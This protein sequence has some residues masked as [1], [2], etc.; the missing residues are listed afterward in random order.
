MWAGSKLVRLVVPVLC[1][2]LSIF[3]TGQTQS[4]G[5]IAGA[6]RD[7]QGAVIVGAEVVVENPATT[8][9]RT[10][11]S[12]S[13]GNYSASLLPPANYDLKVQ[14]KGFTSAIFHNL[15]VG[16][17]GTTTVNAILQVAQTSFEVNV[18][19]A[20]PLLRSDSSELSTTLDSRS[21]TELPLPTRNLLQLLT[22][23][24]GVTAPLTNNNTIGR[25]SPNVSVNGSRV[26]QNSY[27]INGIDANDISLHEF[28]DVAVP[29]PESISEVDVE[30]SLYDASVAGA[31]GSL[32]AVTKS[33]G[34]LL[35]GSAY[36]YFRNE[37]FNAND[38]N[39]KGE[40]RPVMRRNVY[41]ATLGGPLRKNRAFFF[42]AY[43]GTREANGATDQSLYK[44]VLIA[45]GLTNDRS[46]ATLMSTFGVASIDPIAL[47]LLNLQLPNGQFLIPTPQTATGRVTGTALSTYHEEQFS[48][49]VDYRRSRDLLTGKF[50]F[51][52]APL[53]S[54]LAGSNFGTPA[55]LP[56]FGTQITIDNRVLS[57][58][59]I[60]TFSPTAVN[61]IRFGY[62]FIRH[63][64]LPQE[65]VKDSAIGIQRSTSGQYPGLPLIVLGRDEGGASIGTSDITYRGSTPSLSIGDV[66]SLQR[67]KHNLRVGGEI[68]HPEWHGR[69]AVLSYGE[70]D[71]PTF[72][73]FLIGNT[74]FS[75]FG[76]NFGFAHLG[77]GL[78]DR[79]FIT[80]DYHLFAQDDWKIS[81]KFTLNLG[82]RYEL[83]SPPYDSQGRIGGF[84]PAFYRPSMQVDRNGFPLGPP[85][86]GITE[87]GNALP[88]YSLPGVTRV[89]KRV[90]KSIDP[91]NFGP[92]IGLAWSPLNSGRLAIRGG[93][94][95]FYSR[96]S[97]FYLALAYFAPPFFLDSDTSGQPFSNPFA[98]APPESS[99]PLVQP[100]SSVDAEVVDRNARTP[101]TQQF[102]SS[103]QYELMR[104]TT[105]QIAYVGS[106]GGKL[107]RGAA[108]NQAGIAGLSHPITNVVTG[109][110]ITDNTVENAPLRAPLQGVSTAFFSLNGSTAQSTYHSLQATFKR[111]V[112]RGLQFSAVYTFSKSIDNASNPGGGANSDGSLDRSGGL[113]T[114]NT[115]GNQLSSRANRGL[116]DF[117]RTHDFVFNWVW[118]V[119]A[120]SF[121]HGP[122]A[123]RILFSNWQVAGIVT[124]MSGLPVDIFDPSGGSLYG[125]VGARPNWAPGASCKTATTN[126]PPGYYF[127]PSAFV[128]ATVQAGQP[129]PSANDATAL[130]GDVG[131]DV[132]NVGRNLLRGPSQS[133]IDFSIGKRFPLIESKNFEFRADFFNLLNHANTDNPVSDISTSDF[134][135]VLAFSSSPRIVQFALKFTF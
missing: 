106:R 117:D 55:S 8:D 102:N 9:K 114:A 26:T 78:T 40:G 6:V 53:F 72:D 28:A 24:P 13:T 130:A 101:Y 51:A 79:D 33:G 52:H 115:W 20:P 1:V 3:A 124:V 31:G 4:T 135:R 59:E 27:Q 73:D 74:G 128:E 22:L 116:S 120:L 57:L 25:N 119:P 82:L 60:H 14:A 29:A 67:G 81:S 30:P 46:A 121:A 93:Y 32:Q 49:N 71:F 56:G 98:N 90:L 99:F 58:E 39:L 19:D 18:T 76:G 107:F 2:F 100:G 68:R 88:Q 43:Q 127:D 104:N 95:I 5:R 70:I 47:K 123:P 109:E 50:F 132:G 66:L 34:N 87:A 94:G 44:S 62:S 38:A 133:N 36:E 75:Q 80:T 7:S 12:D 91:N 125:L 83:D 84:D 131:T 126:V 103:V 97:F 61:E 96:P 42:A 129:I 17:T 85:V 64:E 86:A 112:S 63:D 118:D 37:V 113:D 35:H 10:T 108:V 21:L 134:G 41:G 89:G 111:Q 45:P 77:T 48:A 11:M 105:L 65:S 110:V 122:I 15:S 69:A 23:A 54:A 92:R 16:L